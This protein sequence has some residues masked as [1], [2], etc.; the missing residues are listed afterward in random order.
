M[1]LMKKGIKS[2]AN[3]DIAECSPIK[4]V[5]C[6]FVPALFVHGE[7][8]DF[9]KP[10]HSQ[11]L[12]DKYAGEKNRI[13]VKGNHNTI[14]PQFMK[15]SASIFFAQCLGLEAINDTSSF[16]IPV[17]LNVSQ[18]DAFVQSNA[19]YERRERQMREEEDMIAQAI[20]LSLMEQEIPEEFAHE[21]G[22]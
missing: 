4:H 3:F 8:D 9:I 7:M 16:E 1:G 14:R 17:G 10:H 20:A 12:C 19:D 6:C 11:V 22:N 21:D 2:R 5:D 18:N 13:L 15:D